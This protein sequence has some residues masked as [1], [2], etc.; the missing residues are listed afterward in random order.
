MGTWINKVQRRIF[1]KGIVELG[2]LSLSGVVLVQF[3]PDK[4]ISPLVIVFGFAN[5]GLCYM[6][7][8]LL[9]WGGDK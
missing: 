3:L 4:P 9:T 5:F 8:Y 2:N 6:I 1:A 7:A